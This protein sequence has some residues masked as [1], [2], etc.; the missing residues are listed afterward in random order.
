MSGSERVVDT[1][2]VDALRARFPAIRESRGREVFFDNAAGAQVPDEVIDAMREHLV[3]RSVNRGGRYGRYREVDDEIAGPRAV[4]TR[5]LNAA[6]PEEIVYGL[7][8]TSLVRMIPDASRP[9]FSPGDHV[10]V[11]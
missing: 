11:T 1:F 10:I 8:E 5:F 2:P 9:H 7:N 6:A 3:Q 4:E